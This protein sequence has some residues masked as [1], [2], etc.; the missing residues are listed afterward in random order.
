MTKLYSH[1]FYD[2]KLAY[3]LF[4]FLAHHKTIT[5]NKLALYIV[6]SKTCLRCSTKD[7]HVILEGSACK[8]VT[9]SLAT[10]QYAIVHNMGVHCG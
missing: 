7:N 6:S 10:T 3:R 9:I 4:H 1:E 2:T 8:L 5:Y